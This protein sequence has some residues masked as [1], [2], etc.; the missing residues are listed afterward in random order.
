MTGRALN[1]TEQ[2]IAEAGHCRWAFPNAYYYWFVGGST[3]DAGIQDRMRYRLTRDISTLTSM[4]RR[5]SVQPVALISETE[6][7]ALLT[8]TLSAVPGWKTLIFGQNGFVLPD[9]NKICCATA[10]LVLCYGDPSDVLTSLMDGMDD[11]PELM[12]RNMHNA[13]KQK[14]QLTTDQNPNGRFWNDV[15]RLRHWRP[16]PTRGLQIREQIDMRPKYDV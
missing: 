4:C 15:D 14:Q 2:H 8:K 16:S 7:D 10:D 5:K 3:S 1:K 6:V 9:A 11:A 13:K 12:R